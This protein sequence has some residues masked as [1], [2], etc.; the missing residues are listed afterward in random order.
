METV[1][2]LCVP[3]NV[4]GFEPR[5]LLEDAQLYALESRARGLEIIRHSLQGADEA[6]S[7]LF[8]STLSERETAAVVAEA[9]H[10]RDRVYALCVDRNEARRLLSWSRI[11]AASIEIPPVRTA[12][13]DFTRIRGLDMFGDRA[14][15]PLL[16]S[17]DAP[18]VLGPK[19][20]WALF[21]GR[22]RTIGGI[23][24]HSRVSAR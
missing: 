22:F 19:A 21:F 2:T 9:A 15:Q 4:I 20:M 5:S 18:S 3:R 12:P 8:I 23:E 24:K 13:L 10:L 6:R 1:E 14:H 16:I 11:S 17:T 7:V